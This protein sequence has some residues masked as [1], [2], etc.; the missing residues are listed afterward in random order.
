M[1]N[2]PKISLGE[3]LEASRAAAAWIR[4]SEAREM[5]CRELGKELMNRLTPLILK[6]SK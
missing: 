5:E 1:I 6:N 3:S 4:E 2:Y